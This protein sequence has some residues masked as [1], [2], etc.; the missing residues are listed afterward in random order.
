MMSRDLNVVIFTC[1]SCTSR[2]CC[3]TY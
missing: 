3:G 2:Y 1:H